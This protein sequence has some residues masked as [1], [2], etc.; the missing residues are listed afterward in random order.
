MVVCFEDSMTHIMLRSLI[1]D[2]RI[3][4]VAIV[5]A[6]ALVFL[7]LRATSPDATLLRLLHRLPPTVRVVMLEPAERAAATGDHASTRDFLRT[8]LDVPAAARSPSMPIRATL[9]LETAENVYTTV[10]IAERSVAHRF[11]LSG[12][13]SGSLTVIGD[14]AE[15]VVSPPAD[16]VALP[17]VSRQQI[18]G[19]TDVHVWLHPR[20]I[21]RQFPLLVPPRGLNTFVALTVRGDGQRLHI[22]GR[23]PLAT[24]ATAVGGRLL[25][26]R[27]EHAVV[28]VDGVPM[29]ALFPSELPPLLEAVRAETGVASEL[30][31]LTELLDGNPS[32][33][34][35]H[36]QPDGQI[37]VTGGVTVDEHTHSTVEDAI[38]KLLSRRFAM[39]HATG[40][41][42]RANGRSIRHVRPQQPSSP[43]ASPDGIEETYRDGW[44]ILRA[45][46]APG[47][48]DLFAAFRD[49]FVLVG[50][51]LDPLLLVG[52][53]LRSDDIQD[54]AQRFFVDGAVG[55]HIPI[56]QF[57]LRG[58][59]PALRTWAEALGQLTVEVAPD[60]RGVQFSANIEWAPTGNRGN[61][62]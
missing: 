57:A 5:T 3:I 8:V 4:I 16:T 38:R 29:S 18:G 36:A 37:A 13:D 50:N 30:R 55:R 53:S 33:L 59:A 44:R 42:V 17:F 40:E 45:S 21:S 2:A 31:A 6:F 56:V 28:I 11:G 35:V 62:P 46:G 24:S 43:A 52:V 41:T 1:G 9:V 23:L 10:M 49:Q 51:A 15:S 61:I 26:R 7:V 27:P 32:L 54:S 25:L 48:S 14:H 58:A 47:H 12:V 39:T 19:E 22:A 60:A 20:W 34:V